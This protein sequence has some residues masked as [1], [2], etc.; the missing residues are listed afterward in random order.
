[1]LSL[2]RI[3]NFAVVEELEI[4][5][6][7][8]LNALTGETGAGK[9]IVLKSM[10]L[11]TGRRASTDIIRTGADQC[12]IEAL[13]ELSDSL[14]KTLS[15]ELEDCAELFDGDEFIVR[16][17]VDRNGKGR[18]YANGRLITLATLARVGGALLDL[19]TQHEHQRLLQPSDQL[20]LLDGF[21]VSA[22]LVADTALAYQN[23]RNAEERLH[24]FTEKA[25]SR[26]EYISR[27]QFERDELKEAALRDGEREET[28]NEL[29]R[30]AHSEALAQHI[31][32][33]L[34]IIDSSHDGM[35]DSFRKILAELSHAAAIDKSLQEIEKLF[36]SA[37]VQVREAKLQLED[38]SA[39][40]EADPA[41]LE[42]LR[43]RVSEI[44]RLER[45]YKRTEAE[46]V[47]YLTAIESELSDFESGEYDQTKLESRLREAREALTKLETKLTAERQKASREL[48]RAI[49]AELATVNMRRARFAVMIS[50]QESGPRGADAIEFRLAANP[51]EEAKSLAKVASG[52]EL[53]RLLLIL[54]TVLS[55]KG[56]FTTQ[57]FDE[58]DT[59]VSGAVAHAVGEKLKTVSKNSQVILVTHSPQIAALA[60][61]HFV[62]DKS[63]RRDRTSTTVRQLEPTERIEEIA[64]MLGG[65]KT[66]EK[67]EQSA[68]ELLGMK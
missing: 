9:S 3:K 40:I 19:T 4:P 64:K 49:E 44:A 63:V 47:L 68:R 66:N 33:V 48:T 32:T 11:L 20:R 35:D 16:R 10:E 41:Q 51:G 5:F 60:D 53:S 65:K 31:G 43:S 50:S 38:Y 18:C 8:G 52:G 37:F 7:E 36:D 21:G 46:L 13:F 57:I 24:E 54:K 39:R 55:E 6:G 15:S 2:L 34:Q 59:G 17:T 29:R 61:Q 58:I 56:N 1:M 22:K 23:F 26:T 12:E 42:A 25:K 28:E 14:R 30:L 62:V 67:F 45:K 27:I